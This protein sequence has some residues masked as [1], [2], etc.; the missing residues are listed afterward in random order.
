MCKV[1]FGS[2][3]ASGMVGFDSPSASLSLLR[4]V[5]SLPSASGCLL[6]SQNDCPNTME[7]ERRRRRA[8]CPTWWEASHTSR[9]FR[10]I[11][12]PQDQ[13]IFLKTGSAG[14]PTRYFCQPSLN[15]ILYTANDS[16]QALIKCFNS[17]SP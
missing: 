3:S 17:A 6:V 10:Q 7:A 13:R 14:S 8:A 4:F 9:N 15:A 5:F 12:I 1:G 16:S 11:T 2:P